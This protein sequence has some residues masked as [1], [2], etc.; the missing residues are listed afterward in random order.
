MNVFKNLSISRFVITLYGLEVSR[1]LKTCKTIK[2]RLQCTNFLSQI[3]CLQVSVL[4]IH[5]Y[6]FY[7]HVHVHNSAKNSFALNRALNCFLKMFGKH[8]DMT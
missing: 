1:S 3:L 5:V 4:I 7:F 6:C 2:S 8:A